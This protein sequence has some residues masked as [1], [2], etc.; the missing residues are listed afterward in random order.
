MNFSAFSAPGVLRIGKFLSV[1][2]LLA[3]LL[4]LWGCQEKVEGL[5]QGYA[6]GESV[7]V[8]APLAGRLEQLASARGS[9]VQAGDLLFVLDRAVEQA[10]V[11]AAVQQVRSAESRLEDLRK[12]QRPRELQALRSRQSQAR[13]KLEQAR[14]SLDEKSQNAPQQALV[15]DTLFEAGE[16]VPAGT[17]VVSLLPPGNIKLRF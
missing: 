6:E 4:L 8:A 9:Q 5:F 7:L 3:T 2:S 1:R 15:F 16:F 17:P 10:A 11:A 14:W 13:A 12:G